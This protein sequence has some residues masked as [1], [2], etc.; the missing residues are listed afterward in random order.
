MKVQVLG[1]SGGIGVGEFTTCVRINED[2][3]LDAGTGLGC[4]T[5]AEL[6]QLRHVFITHS[7][8]DH[9][10]LLPMLIDN[11]FE[12][13]TSPIHVYGVSPVLESLHQHI[14]NWKIWPDFTQ[15]PSADA[16]VMA[17]TTLTSNEPFELGGVS[18]TP[19]DVEHVVPTTGYAIV[20][21]GGRLFVFTSDT[22]LNEGLIKSL[23]QMGPI[24]SLMIECAMPSRMQDLAIASK[25]MTPTMLKEL[26]LCLGTMPERILISHIKPYYVDEVE[27]ELMSLHLKSEL[28]LLSSGQFFFL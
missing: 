24:H 9:V 18:F 23:N 20:S 13:L 27:A 19:F 15:L 22:T 3:L 7:H 25:H 6:T 26:L 12:L 5:Q 8:L 14:F 17:F 11:Q 16:P 2:I 10:C 1:C 21:E 4:L 28:V